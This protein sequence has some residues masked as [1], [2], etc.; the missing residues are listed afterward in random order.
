MQQLIESILPLLIIKKPS[1]TITG[2]VLACRSVGDMIGSA[3]G[4]KLLDA[5]HRYRLQT[6]FGSGLAFVVIF[7]LFVSYYFASFIG[8]CLSMFLFG[9]CTYVSV[10]P[11]YD[12]VLQH[13]YPLNVIL[14]TSVG[15]I[16]YF[17]LTVVISE[18]GRSFLHFKGPLSVL[19]FHC[20]LQ[21]VGFILSFFIKPNLNRSRQECKGRSQRG[22]GPPQIEMLS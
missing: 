10:P 20:V 11:L 19:I 5:F 7:G 9:V 3:I 12:S 4:G 22:S 14:V 2:Y 6:I 13:T 17:C 1:P 18:I 15:G 21:L 8:L 16:L